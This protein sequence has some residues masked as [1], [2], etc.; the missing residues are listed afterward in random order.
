MG[1]PDGMEPLGFTDKVRDVLLKHRFTRDRRDR[2]SLMEMQV[3]LKLARKVEDEGQDTSDETSRA[4]AV[5]LNQLGGPTNALRFGDVV[6]A[7]QSGEVMG[8]EEAIK[9]V[10]TR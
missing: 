2:V 3:L 6:L 4:V 5:E 1:T 7:I 8:L 10:A 9:K